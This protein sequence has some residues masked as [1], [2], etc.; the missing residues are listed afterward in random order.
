MHFWSIC[1]YSKTKQLNSVAWVCE[2]TL[3]TKRPLLVNEVSAN[4]GSI[5]G[6]LDRSRYFLQVA[7]QLYTHE[8]EWDNLVAPGIE[9]IPLDL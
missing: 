4:K 1:I 2:R 9:P 3:P 8:T 7:P 6:F 5:L